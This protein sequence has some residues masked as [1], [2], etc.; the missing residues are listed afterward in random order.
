MLRQAAYVAG[1]GWAITVLSFSDEAHLQDREIEDSIFLKLILGMRV[2][3]SEEGE[4]IQ[5][6]VQWPVLILI[7]LL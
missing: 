7:S 5:D 1:R 3:I 6:R 2:V 4:L